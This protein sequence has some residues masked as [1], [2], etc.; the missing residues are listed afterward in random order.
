M[1]LHHPS[2]LLLLSSSHSALSLASYD[3]AACQYPSQDPL[4]GCPPNTV[5]VGPNTQ[6][7]TIQAAIRSIGPKNT[8][9]AS[10]TILI[11]PGNYTEQLNITHSAPLTLLGVTIYPNDA[12]KN[13]VNIIWHNATGTNTTGSYDNAYTSTLTVAPTLNAGLTGSGPTGFPVPKGFMSGSWGMWIC[14]GVWLLDR[15]ILCTAS[16]R[17][18]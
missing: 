8:G 16:E 9:N 17:S 3:R 12:T 11:P 18:G 5:L 14:M 10:H 4:Q 13:A 1:L 15:R 2:S 7:E 6:Y